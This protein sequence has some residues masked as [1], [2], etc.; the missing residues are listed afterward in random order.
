VDLLHGTGQE[1][2]LSDDI[3]KKYPGGICFWCRF[4]LSRHIR[5][6]NLPGSDNILGFITGL[7]FNAAG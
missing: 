5:W 3:H 4:V 6:S 7:R 1:E 2:M